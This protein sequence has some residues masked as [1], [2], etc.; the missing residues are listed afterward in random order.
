[1]PK[2]LPRGAAITPG[3]AE[4]NDALVIFRSDGDVTEDDKVF[5]ERGLLH[6]ETDNISIIGATPATIYTWLSVDSGAVPTDGIYVIDD[7]PPPPDRV[8][9]F[10]DSLWGRY[11]DTTALKTVK[12]M[13]EASRN[14][15]MYIA[16]VC[17]CILV[18]VMGFGVMPM[19]NSH[20]LSNAI[21]DGLHRT[22][23]QVSDTID[24]LNTPDG[25][26]VPSL[27]PET[28]ENPIL[29]ETRPP[30]PVPRSRR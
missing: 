25:E 14:Q 6:A 21:A 8:S 11:T 9:A 22:Q 27:P 28:Q 15:K 12:Q 13:R 18:I 23:E 5:Y 3:K 20:N 7:E 2:L 4:S 17:A 30:A 19:W 29:D 26:E 16:T 10:G 1:M 24:G